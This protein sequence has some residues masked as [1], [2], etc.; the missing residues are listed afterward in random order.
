MEEFRIQRYLLVAGINVDTPFD[1]KGLETSMATEWM[2][3][4]FPLIHADRQKTYSILSTSK[5][6]WTLVRVTFIE[7]KNDDAEIRVSLEDCPGKRINAG[8][9]AGFLTTQLK[10][11]TYCKKSPFIANKE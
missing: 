6:D 11:D 9:I 10:V 5:V 1:K 3:A 7:F 4:N 2:K 8:C